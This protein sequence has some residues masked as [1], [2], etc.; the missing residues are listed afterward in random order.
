[1]GNYKFQG[2]TDSFREDLERMVGADDSNFSGL[3]LAALIRNKYG[4]SYD[5][6]LIKKVFF[7]MK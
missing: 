6:Q 1:M 7:L 3:D 5:V 4:R 2:I